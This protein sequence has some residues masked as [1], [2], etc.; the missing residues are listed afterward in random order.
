[1][2]FVYIL[3]CADGSLY[4]GH[5]ADPSSHE[6]WHNEGTGPQYTASRLPVHIV[7]TESFDSLQAAVAREAVE[8]VERQEEGSTHLRQSRRAEAPEQTAPK[9]KVLIVSSEIVRPPL[10]CIGERATVGKP[11]S[12][13]HH[14]AEVVHRSGVVTEVDC[15]LIAARLA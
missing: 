7:Y 2:H 10:A 1:V 3:R 4:V 12:S 9:V 8:E 13:H 11:A 15:F 6:R 14:R 5:S